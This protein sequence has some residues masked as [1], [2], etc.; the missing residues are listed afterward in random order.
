M[1]LAGL[2]GVGGVAIDSA[3]DLDD[4]DD[5]GGVGGLDA[6]FIAFLDVT[7]L[8]VTCL[9]W[10]LM[11]STVTKTDTVTAATTTVGI[12]IPRE[13]P[14][15]NWSIVELESK[16]IEIRLEVSTSLIWTP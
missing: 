4:I 3:G 8:S 13:T 1:T 2:G 11:N 9:L 6:G 16:V 14:M 7:G 15:E 5:F 12:T 10:R